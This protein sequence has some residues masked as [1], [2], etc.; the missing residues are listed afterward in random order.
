MMARLI[1]ILFTGLT[2]TAAA[3]DGPQ[4]LDAVRD[5]VHR[6]LEQRFASGSGELRIDVG[7][8]DSRLRLQACD[9][10]L[11]TFFPQGDGKLGNLTV[12][13]RCH[14][15]KPWTLY[16]PAAVKPYADV[17]V[18][19][20]T[21]S[22]GQTLSRGDV[23]L[24]KRDLTRLGSGY[25]TSMNA[26]LGKEVRRPV[27]VGQVLT[28]LAIGSPTR[29]RRGQRVDLVAATPGLEVRMAGKTLADAAV[30]DTVR[31]RNLSSKRIV[32]GVVTQAGN[33]R[34]QL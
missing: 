15:P 33:V 2:A 29:L 26:V 28:R 8:L 17:I 21:L 11:D 5:T 30:G 23:R 31:V 12:G 20:R 9:T 13:V 16:V 6:F 10:P 24:E 14:S 4:P 27:T 3:A 7:R 25:Y 1:G 18:L 34:I 19:T 32:E 22:R